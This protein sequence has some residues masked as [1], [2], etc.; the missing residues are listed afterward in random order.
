M[1][2]W[3][4]IENFF[5]GIY[6]LP[7]EVAAAVE[8]GVKYLW[9]TITGVFEAVY[10]AWED[11]VH[12]AEQIG[13]AIE[14]GFLAAAHY[15]Q[16]LVTVEIPRILDWV[17]SQLAQ[18]GHDIAAAVKDVVA[19]AERLYNDA[20]GAVKAAER[21][22]ETSIWTPLYD[23]LA[24]IYHWIE[25]TGDVMWG[26]IEHPE[27]LAHLLIGY[28]WSATIW[29]IKESLVPIAHFLLAGIYTAMLDTADVIESIFADML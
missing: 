15:A 22:V 7:G 9:D 29:L 23:S 24:G 13:E 19:L 6:H 4:D 5:K 26:Y 3:G 12:G 18:L 25:H 1:S 27:T 14:N 20:I 2:I 16:W 21:W 11:V 28:L 17:G 10:H 8:R